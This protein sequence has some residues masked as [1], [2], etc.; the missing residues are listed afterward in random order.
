[1]SE[2]QV[3]KSNY[4]YIDTSKQTLLTKVSISLV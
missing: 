3:I 4:S 1:M 2:L